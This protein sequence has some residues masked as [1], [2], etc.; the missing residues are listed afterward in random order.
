MERRAACL[1]HWGSDYRIRQQVKAGRLY[2]VERGIYAEEPSVP[3]L[4]VLAVKYPK[5]IFTMGTAFY[6]GAQSTP[7]ESALCVRRG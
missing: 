1:E 6:P 7:S 2:R 4:V 5:A 3:E